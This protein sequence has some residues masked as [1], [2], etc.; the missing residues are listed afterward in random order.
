MSS[1]G[2]GG[3]SGGCVGAHVGGH[4]HRRAGVRTWSSDG[5]VGGRRGD[6]RTAAGAAV[7]LQSRRI[8]RPPRWRSAGWR[9]QRHPARP[10]RAR[11]RRAA[12]GSAG[13]GG[14]RVGSGGGDG[15]SGGSCGTR[16]GGHGRGTAGGAMRRWQLRCSHKVSQGGGVASGVD[17]AIGDGGDRATPLHTSS[18]VPEIGVAGRVC[19]CMPAGREGGSARLVVGTPPRSHRWRLRR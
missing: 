19:S 5:K 14:A 1:D 12:G 9:L 4:G 11:R 6:G 13:S 18:V 2:G 7:G 10:K 17:D 15:G 3:G 16:D 8:R